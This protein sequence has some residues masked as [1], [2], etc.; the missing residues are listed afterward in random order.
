MKTVEQAAAT[1]DWCATSPLLVGLSGVYCKD[2]NIA[3]INTAEVGRK[4]VAPWAADPALAERLWA[5]AEAM[6]GISQP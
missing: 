4:D 1:S 6:V 2:S 3:E 5:V